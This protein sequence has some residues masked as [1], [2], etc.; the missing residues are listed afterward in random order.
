M[1][2]L[3]RFKKT[4]DQ[5]KDKAADLAEE[6]GDTAKGAL[7]KAADVVGDKT[8]HQHDAKIDKGVDAAKGAIDKLAGDDKTS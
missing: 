3:D 1:G 8:K 6:H 5:V 4:A 7:D 2:L